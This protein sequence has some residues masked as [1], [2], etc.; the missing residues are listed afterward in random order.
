MNAF[1]VNLSKADFYGGRSWAQSAVIESWT[2]IKERHPTSIPTIIY[3]DLGR[4]WQ[5]IKSDWF[6]NLTNYSKL[7]LIFSESISSFC[8]AAGC[9]KAITGDPFKSL[10]ILRDVVSRQFIY[11]A[12]LHNRISELNQQIV[13]QQRMITALAYRYVLESLTA[14]IPGHS[15]TEKWH[16]F[17]EKVFRNVERDD[18]KIPLNNPF[19]DLF[20][21]HK[22]DKKYP[23]GYLK[24]MA[25]ELYS[26]LSRTI[27]NFQPSK[28]FGQ[29]TPMPGQFDPMQIDFLVAMK[30][31]ST[32]LNDD[33]NPN[34]EKERARYPGQI[35]DVGLPVKPKIQTKKTA[36]NLKKKK[37]R[38]TTDDDEDAILAITQTGLIHSDAMEPLE[39]RGLGESSS[40]SGEDSESGYGVSWRFESRE[41]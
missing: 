3:D 10:E 27:H 8:L 11:T 7:W 29:Y 5:K 23:I 37:H 13:L 24:E 22:I 16:S 12:D 35:E 21:Q 36:K 17:L 32:N 28:D 40:T 41:S 34:W 14:E 18:G 38:S 31:D 25:K 4:V 6:S 20:D 1:L 2:N 39:T 26:T 30:P 33:G 19:N 15:A 9:P